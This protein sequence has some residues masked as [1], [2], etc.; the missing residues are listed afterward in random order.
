METQHS[1][2]DEE[3]IE[4]SWYESILF[5]I[6][7][8]VHQVFTVSLPLSDVPESPSGVYLSAASESSLLVRIAVPKSEDGAI[9]TKYKG[10][11]F[12][13]SAWSCACITL[14][15]YYYT[16]YPTTP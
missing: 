3:R 11:T 15:T 13:N 14:I 7:C 2:P 10:M 16:L 9:V 4:M 5:E 12:S 8:Q 6:P 1:D